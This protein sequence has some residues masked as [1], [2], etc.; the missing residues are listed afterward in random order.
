MPNP[1]PPYPSFTWVMSSA[2]FATSNNMRLPAYRV[3]HLSRFHPYPRSHPSHHEDRFL[4]RSLFF[5]V[6]LTLT[7]GADHH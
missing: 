4:V 5:R 6:S 1:Q 2:P 7:L 3:S